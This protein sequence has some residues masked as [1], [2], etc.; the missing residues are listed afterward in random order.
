MKQ[1]FTVRIS[2]ATAIAATLLAGCNSLATILNQAHT[3]STVH[4][5]ME[6]G[7]KV[8]NYYAATPG[9]TA[10]LNNLRGIVD[11]NLVA[12]QMNSS[13]SRGP[14][15][16]NANIMKPDV[17]APGTDILAAV[18]ADLTRDQR[19]AVAA[20]SPAPSKDFAFYTEAYL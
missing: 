15:V 13:S 4:I 8:K 7:Q 11:P 1:P 17:T 9:A 12:P 10:A 20:G 19:N 16:A 2:C 14:N 3:I 18:S 5:T 6:D